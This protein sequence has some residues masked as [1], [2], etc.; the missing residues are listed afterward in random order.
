MKKII[1][2]SYLLLTTCSLLLAQD[3][4]NTPYETKFNSIERSDLKILYKDK[5]FQLGDPFESVAP[6]FGDAPMYAGP[7]VEIRCFSEYTA[8]EV[9]Q[10]IVFEDC[11]FLMFRKGKLAFFSLRSRPFKVKLTG[12]SDAKSKVV[13]IKNGQPLNAINP[14]DKIFSNSYKEKST[15]GDSY[16]DIL[17]VNVGGLNSADSII[18][19]DLLISLDKGTDRVNAFHFFGY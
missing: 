11:T 4:E 7:F 1:F 19:N 13:T 5:A 8:E 2:L 18:G 16:N 14:F 17:T 10:I 3:V 15:K 12:S 9:D 6:I